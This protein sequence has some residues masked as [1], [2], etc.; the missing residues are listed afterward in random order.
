MARRVVRPTR[1]TCHNCGHV[2]TGAYCAACG[3]PEREGH[4]PTLGHF[5]HDLLHE[6][7]HIDGKIFLTLKAL[8]FHPGKLTEEYWAGRVYSW[9]RP[10][11][12]FLII[13]ALQA[14]ASQGQGPLNHRVRVER[15]SSGDLSVNIA[16]DMLRFENKEEHIPA[17]ETEV[18]EFSHKF[19]KAYGAARYSSVLVFATL[20]WL[21]YRRRQPYFISQLIAGLH[22]YSFWYALALL[23][24]LLSRVDPLWKNLP[25]LSAAYLFFA[26]LRL[27]HEQWYRT[28][29]KTVVLYGLVFATELGLGYAA[30]KFVES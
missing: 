19:E 10:I 28:L 29:A 11:R 13:V 23:A 14:L 25:V 2:L 24:S 3:Q 18:L 20:A 8:F 9:V 17:S 15:S 30:A 27:F 12:I 26:L 16:D 6:F 7:L 22:F 1:E 4:P 21:L 5:F